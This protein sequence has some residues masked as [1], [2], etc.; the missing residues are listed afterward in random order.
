MDCETLISE[1]MEN[2]PLWDTKN[3]NYSNKIVTENIW[4]SISIVMNAPKI[5]CKKKFK[6]LKDEY[7][8]ALRKVPQPGA[9]AETF[10]SKFKYFEL[11]SFLRD[12]F[13][14]AGYSHKRK[15]DLDESYVDTE[16]KNLKPLEAEIKRAYKEDS[17]D[18]QFFKSL[19][20]YVKNISPLQKLQFRS[21][22]INNIIEITKEEG[23]NELNV[24][25]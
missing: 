2:P 21:N 8:K 22:L 13:A 12:D 24:H 7:R 3:K 4:D 19:L 1:I 14:V 20:P 9:E 17:D 6:Y 15:T 16:K 5:Q 25:I 11:M 23:L 10:V 18:L